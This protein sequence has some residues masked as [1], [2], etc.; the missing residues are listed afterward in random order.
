[1][2]QNEK[3]NNYY[4][5]LKSDI[6]KV[7]MRKI[8]VK[9][10]FEYLSAHIMDRTGAYI[11]PMT[12]RRFW[13]ELAG[14]KYNVQ[15]RRYTLDVLARYAGHSNYE[16]FV[17]FCTDNVNADSNFIAGEYLIP[18]AI[19]KGTHIY[20]A[21]DPGHYIVA[22][23]LGCE[24]FLIIESFKSKLSKDDTFQV[25][26]ITQGEPLYLNRLIHEGS[27]PIRYVCGK[28][29][30]VRFRVTNDYKKDKK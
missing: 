25:D 3:E 24:M 13:G 15:P 17:K 18:S 8:A 16:Q 22:E 14:G 21:W 12:L 30:G 23:Y 29:G 4:E 20:I 9:R 11:S 27:T 7:A 28:K 10:D 2:A 5:A 26:T 1:M 19:K 6:E